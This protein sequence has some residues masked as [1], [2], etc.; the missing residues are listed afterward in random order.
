VVPVTHSP[1]APRK[2]P[3]ITRTA[4]LLGAEALSSIPSSNTA[5]DPQPKARGRGQFL[6]VSKDER[7]QSPSPSRL[8][9]S[10]RARCLSPD[11]KS[12]DSIQTS[13]S[14]APSRKIKGRLPRKA[15]TSKPTSKVIT[16]C[17]ILALAEEGL[18]DPEIVSNLNC[19][20]DEYVM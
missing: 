19:S 8:P 4:G 18:Q 15:K 16:N 7:E 1:A 2:T 20:G 3:P 11:E 10:P 9:V 5:F 6:M 13:D 14:D 17:E 12:E